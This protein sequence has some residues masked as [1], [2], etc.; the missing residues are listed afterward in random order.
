MLDH[1]DIFVSDL[2]KSRAF[3][4]AALAPLGFAIIEEDAAY[5]GVSLGV[6]A[7]FGRSANPAGD[8]WLRA[9]APSMPRPHFAFT[10]ASREA[11][12]AFH[13]AALAAGGRDNGRPG[14]R[15]YS[16][17]YYAAFVFDPDGYNI[18]AV[19]HEPAG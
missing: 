7:G 18:E 4:A 12:D 9:A 11:V 5:G 15:P 1:L 6:A 8:L 13:A 10:A 3:Y 17:G 2:A 14:L 16:P 19:C